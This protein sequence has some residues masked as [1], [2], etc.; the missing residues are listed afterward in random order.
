MKSYSHPGKSKFMFTLAVLVF[1]AFPLFIFSQKE[2]EKEK[3]KEEKIPKIT[4][5]ILV[6]GKAPKELPVST[7]IRLDST[8]IENL[9]PL[10]LSE[11]IKY[12]PGVMV[13]FGDK[14]EYNLKLRGMDSKRIVLLIDGIPVYE[15]YYGSFD[16]KTISAGGIDS[17][18][19]TTGPSS[20]L[21]GPNTLGGIVN[22]ITRRPGPD[23]KLSLDASYGER[24]T[25]S[26]GLDSA[27]Q[28]KRLA[29]A[30]SAYYQD[31]DGYYYPSSTGNS[32][33]ARSNSDYQRLN[34]NAK[35]YYNPSS[36]AEIMVNGGI[37]HSEYGMPA[38]LFAQKARYWRFKNW[39]RY[40]LNAGGF[41]FLGNNSTLRFR[42]FF[43]N[44]QNTLDQYRDQAMTIRQFESS[45]DNSVYG[46]FA[47]GDF[48]LSKENSLKASLTYQ[49]DR[50]RT[51]DDISLPWD[52][53]NQGTF[54]AGLEDHF[55]FAEK[56]KLVGGLSLD[57]LAKFEGKNRSSVNPLAGLRFSP[58]DDLELHLSFSM[59]SR[60]PSMRSMYSP[61]SGNPDLLS[62]SGTNAELGF[63]YDKG[64]FITGGAFLSRF[65][66]L[67]NTVRLPDG[68][69]RYFNIGKAHINGFE[70]QVQKGFP[71]LDATLNYTYLDH[72]NESDDRPLD[73]LPNHT[74]NFDLGLHL[75]RELRL[76]FFGFYASSSSWYDTST[77]TNFSIPSYFYLN[78]VLSYAFPHAEFFVK[79]TNIFN[80]DYYT[81]PGFPCQGRTLEV[82][83]R[84]DIFG[85]Y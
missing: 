67:I 32:R 35:L 71:W 73:A 58:N 66:N 60:F 59:K 46:L 4:E 20:V 74:L 45:F 85:K 7:V 56:W 3:K 48:Y 68:T 62:E 37:Y 76:G 84:A 72:R 64:M 19:I 10:D 83:F 12:A 14:D 23:P 65:K 22:V 36:A 40:T 26:L 55:A 13:T 61:S 51:Q 54:S 39:D 80:Q 16:L 11:A 63:T 1:L 21:Y 81:E 25:R 69:R 9:K 6:V 24:N 52:E 2:D 5:E 50:A 44:Y 31:S 57:Y 17:L 38:A 43:V 78:S 18:Q 49:K 75:L 15:P 28:W 30:G 53:F 33:I 47:L 41:A 82:G 8:K 29:F 34:L 27:F 42:V 79:L 70:L 77:K